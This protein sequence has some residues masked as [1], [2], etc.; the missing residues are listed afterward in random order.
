[1]LDGRIA[2]AESTCIKA[3]GEIN[4]IERGKVHAGV[5]FRVLMNRR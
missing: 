3:E 1:M 5:A 2:N 4:N